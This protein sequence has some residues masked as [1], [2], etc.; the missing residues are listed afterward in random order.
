MASSITSICVKDVSACL[1]KHL[2]DYGFR[3]R[4]PHLWRE[5]KDVTQMLH[6]QSSQ[7]G[8]KTEGNFTINIAVTHPQLFSL[9]T[10]RPF[11]TNPGTATWP[12]VERIGNLVDDGDICWDVN[13]S[14]DAEELASGI[15]ER[16]L[17]PLLDGFE[18]YDSLESLKQDLAKF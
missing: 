1:L 14:T 18:R 5:N 17:A 13:E 12:I 10:G 7:W 6:F 8:T 15:S 11:P 4:S 16:Y 3:R 2:S 9:W